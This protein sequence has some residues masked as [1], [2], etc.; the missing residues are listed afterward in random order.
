LLLLCT[1]CVHLH[2]SPTELVINLRLVQTTHL[3][4]LPPDMMATTNYAGI[5]HVQDFRQQHTA[6]A[7]QS[8][9]L[10]CGRPRSS[11][12]RH[13]IQDSALHNWVCSRRSCAEVKLLLRK[14][15]EVDAATTALT[16]Q[17]HH[18][19]PIDYCASNTLAAAHIS[20]LHAETSQKSCVELPGE[21]FAYQFPSQG[22]GRLPTIYEEPPYVSASTKPSAKEVR[23]TL[24]KGGF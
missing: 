10:R 14:A 15:S 6:S 21:P 1:S 4:R 5:E 22:Y 11:R 2:C 3:S 18:Y 23:E 20:E 19:Y 7:K 24:S 13:T 16:V 17:I 12:S 9:C 8:S